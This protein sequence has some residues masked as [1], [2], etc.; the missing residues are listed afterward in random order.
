MSQTADLLK[1]L[2]KALREAGLTYAQ[3]G[4]ALEL[5]EASVKRLFHRESFSLARLEAVCA[6]M[7]LTPADL[8]ERLAASRPRVTELSVEQ[9]QELVAD[10]R[11][12]LLTY[13]LLNHWQLDEILAAYSFGQLELQK[14][15]RRLE[16]LS[17]VRLIPGG[18]IR[19]LTA[20]NFAW[21]ADGPVQ[22]YIIEQV[23]PQYFE[24]GFGQTD[25]HFRFI[26]GSMSLASA[27]QVAEAFQ[28][29]IEEFDRLVERDAKLPLEQRS[30]Y[31]AVMALRPFRYSV[32]EELEKQSP[33]AD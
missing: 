25:R 10:P 33:E 21:R 15:L 30:A 16:Q 18:R 8:F 9:E 2:K 20:R 11:L 32:F 22:R 14:L 31:T 1:E 27:G 17:L 24:A 28:R 6:L 29:C 4:E 19:L 3:V 7:E 13:L 12:F 26:A 23:L 5:S